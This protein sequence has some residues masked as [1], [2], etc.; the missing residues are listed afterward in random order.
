MKAAAAAAQH[1]ETILPLT[2]LQRGILFQCQ[3]SSVPGLYVTQLLLRL[4][5]PLEPDRW[6]AAWTGA[7]DRHQALRAAFYWDNRRDP[8]QV[9]LRRSDPPWIEHDL[10]GEGPHGLNVEAVV[11]RARNHP[12]SL[13]KGE[14]MSHH[15]L[16]TG[17]D[18]HVHVWT[19]HHVLL[20]GWSSQVVLGDVWDSYAGE[21]TDPV[22]E[23]GILQE[24]LSLPSR[25]DT[26]ADRD[27]WAEVLRDWP[28][29][30]CPGANRPQVV[31]SLQTRQRRIELDE[32]DGVRLRDTCRKAG[33]TI[34][35]VTLGAWAAALARNAGRDEAVLGTAHAGRDVE[36]S[37]RVVGM[38]MNT[39]PL[40]VGIHWDEPGQGWL[41]GVQSAQM[42]AIAHGTLPV[43]ELRDIAGISPREALFQT[44]F[45]YENVPGGVDRPARGVTLDQFEYVDR[46]SVPLALLVHPGHGVTLQANY[47]HRVVGDDTVDALL[48]DLR[49]SLKVFAR[50]PEAPV[51]D[52]VAVAVDLPD[53]WG[54]EPVVAGGFDLSPITLDIWQRAA[55]QP[56]DVALRRGEQSIPYGELVLRADRYARGLVRS[57]VPRGAAL[58]V[59]LPPEPDTISLLLGVLRA[60]CAYVPFDPRGPAGRL[61]SMVDEL[62]GVGWD[63]V[64]PIVIVPALGDV[65]A[66]PERAR[67]VTTRELW[68]N[69]EAPGQIGR[70]VSPEDLAYLIYTS[71]STGRP[72]GVPVKHRNLAYSTRCR[73]RHYATPPG[74]F[75][76]LSPLFFDSSVVGLYWTL[77]SG[78]ELVFGDVPLERNLDRVPAWIERHRVSHILCLPSLYQLILST[79][80]P[81]QLDTL[82]CVILA[83]EAFPA[84]IARAHR[85]AQLEATLH[86]E[87]GPTE[88]SVW[89]SVQQVVPGPDL[90]PVPIGRGISG[91][92]LRVLDESGRQLGPGGTGEIAVAGPGVVDGYL[93]DPDLTAQRFREVGDG[94]RVY[95][96]GDRG[97]VGQDGEVVF[98][99]RVDHQIKLQGRRVEPAEAESALRSCPGI[100]EAAVVP[101]GA[102]DAGTATGLAAFLVESRPVDEL[103]LTSWIQEHLPDYL[104]PRVVERVA[105]LPRLANGKLDRVALAERAGRGRSG[106][107]AGGVFAAPTEEAIGAVWSEVLGVPDVGRNDDFF[108]LGGDS[109]TAVLA[110]DKINQ[111][112]HSSLAIA[113]LYT[114]PT[115]AD[116]AQLADRPGDSDDWVRTVAIRAEGGRP[117]LFMAYGNAHQ[118]AARLGPDQ[119][120]YWLIEGRGSTVVPTEDFSSLAAKH[121]DQ[122]RRIQPEGPYRLAGFS[123]GAL[124]VLELARALNAAGEQVERLLLID[125]TRASL[126][127][128][129]SRYGRLRGMLRRPA[130]LAEKGRYLLRFGW[131]LP[132][133]L[134][135]KISRTMDRAGT[136]VVADLETGTDHV[137]EDPGGPLSHGQIL[138]LVQHRLD[139]YTAQPYS[140]QVLLV[141]V[142]RGQGR[143]LEEMDEETFWHEL[144]PAGLELQTLTT[145]T[146]HRNLFRDPGL[147]DR[148]CVILDRELLGPGTTTDLGAVP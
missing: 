57:G 116:L 126:F 27:Y 76:L 69:G 109:L 29:A 100:R 43:S 92:R 70:T 82:E 128:V 28:G 113:D 49:Q 8:V 18:T 130:P 83:G 7:T 88:A 52:W 22:P 14:L 23:S 121:L 68:D 58:A 2:P 3:A 118:L 146:G 30:T 111:A 41:R 103:A 102:T 33:L 4:R 11:E 72:K 37:E 81:G 75:L 96:T 59:C 31:G 44:L 53:A 145:G 84:S 9:I 62:A 122:V 119:P 133:F 63:D 17:D 104:I 90:D 106:G 97:T 125:P 141:R 135:D 120:V 46:T 15:L 101:L 123:L 32:V 143:D 112:L 98:A 38:L 134:R 79:A 13:K 45:V 60:G 99:G 19:F 93:F 114:A 24:Y 74:R 148:L 85:G 25:A 65:M 86:N 110:V 94:S 124:V 16:R 129:R 1:I 115:L 89:C 5:G 51:R 147:L 66:V 132:E 95:M 117:P 39:I 136:P 71:G 80:S 77:A 78:G 137:L 42:R 127:R 108:R 73:D 10:R 144:A 47:D 64:Q 140:G 48:H 138:E 6:R 21:P 87:Y 56:D 50:E 131:R 35:A 91:T 20:D 142:D 105:E 12:F 36:G 139:E 67:A 107:G 34:G 61:T 26:G 55:E 40:R 54:E